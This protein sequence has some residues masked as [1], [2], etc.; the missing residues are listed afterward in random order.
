M[1]KGRF[2]TSAAGSVALAALIAASPFGVQ[3]DGWDEGFR[4]E[5]G[6]ALAK[7]G[8]DDD[9]DDS[10]GSG[11]G[12]D[13][14]GSDD[15]DRGDR[16]RDRDDRDRSRSDD[17]DDDNRGR[18]RGR[19]RGGDDKRTGAEHRRDDDRRDDRRGGE[20]RASPGGGSQGDVYVTKVEETP[21]GIE[22]EYSNGA[23]EE[24]EQGRYERK[25]VYGRTVVERPAS[26]EDYGRIRSNIVNSGLEMARPAG[27]PARPAAQLPPDSVARKVELGRQAIEVRYRDG[28][29]EEISA[30]RYQ[31]K[32]PNNRTVVERLATEADRDRLMALAGQ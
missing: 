9:G 26:T 1:G 30:G 8:D 32:D 12:G 20:R 31:L 4:L 5:A 27:N 18:G 10:S 6:Q 2:T 22:V 23:K 11:S 17:R 24:I 14:S 13:R 15:S 25:D 28:W 7:G 16:G 19:G 21:W 29:K 3:F